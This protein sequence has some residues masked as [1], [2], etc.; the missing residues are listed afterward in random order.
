M[1]DVIAKVHIIVALKLSMVKYS[2]IRTFIHTLCIVS[3]LPTLYKMRTVK[4]LVI[5]HYVKN[6]KVK[7][8]MISMLTYVYYMCNVC[9]YV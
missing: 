8:T 4:Q 3:P 2:E 9:I 6:L 1:C 5:V 7:R